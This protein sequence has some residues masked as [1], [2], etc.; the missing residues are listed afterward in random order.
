MALLC[1]LDMRGILSTPESDVHVRLKT[2][3]RAMKI[4]RETTNIINN[5]NMIQWNGYKDN[6]FQS[7]IQVLG[8]KC[9]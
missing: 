4:G 7:R 6:N 5:R 3:G 8:V 1:A 2:T 9:L